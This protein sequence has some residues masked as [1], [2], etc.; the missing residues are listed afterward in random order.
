MDNEYRGFFFLL[1]DLEKT[2]PIFDSGNLIKTLYDTMEH[3]PRKQGVAVGKYEAFKKSR[4]AKAAD[5]LLPNAARAQ[6]RTLNELT[7]DQ[8]LR[9]FDNIIGPNGLNLEARNRQTMKDVGEAKN[10]LTRAAKG[11]RILQIDM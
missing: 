10:K 8:M 1:H 9:L 6:G 11:S 5:K 7:G 3:P 4:A 2:P